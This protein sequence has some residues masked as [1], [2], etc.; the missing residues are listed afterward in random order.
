MSVPWWQRGAIY[1]IY[2][3][4]FA[5]ADGDGVGDLRGHRGAARLPRPT[6]AWR[7]CGCRRSTPRRW[8][9]SA[10]TWP[11]TATSIPPSARSPTSTGLIAEAHAPRDPRH[12]RLGARTTPRTGTRGSWPRARAARIPGATGTCGATR[13]GRRPA[14]QLAS[15][16]E[17][18]G[19]AWTL[20]PAH[21]PVVPALVH[22]RAARPQLGQPRGRGGDARRAALLARPR[23]GRLPDRR[24]STRSPRT[25]C[26]AT[27]PG[28][29]PPRR[30]LGDD[31]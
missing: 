9:T 21:R 10:T 28:R 1:Q 20:R 15:T 24:R 26:C 18:V 23:R 7:R 13:P 4:S 29:P 30:G 5:D 14:Q 31:P 19:P 25:R 8:P 16:F 6:S 17:R 22:A 11:T 27:T 12:P 2:P 3:R